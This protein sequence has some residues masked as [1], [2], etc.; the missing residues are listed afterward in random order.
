MR[1]SKASVWGLGNLRGRGQEGSL[2]LQPKTMSG[3]REYL[4]DERIA[5]GLS[6]TVKRLGMWEF[7]W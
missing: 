5:K 1:G 7:S 2:G 3:S 4:V 6:L